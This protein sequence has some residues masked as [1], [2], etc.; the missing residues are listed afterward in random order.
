M[1][2]VAVEAA[3]LLDAVAVSVNEYAHF[4]DDACNTCGV[5]DD[6]A[7]LAEVAVGV[8]TRQPAQPMFQHWS[9]LQN[10]NLKQSQP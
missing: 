6:A 3:V 2:A 4:R 5:G 10:Q 9:L 1:D 8:V 7:V